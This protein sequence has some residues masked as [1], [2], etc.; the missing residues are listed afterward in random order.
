MFDRH[1]FVA[2][3]APTPRELHCLV[4]HL[5]D[6]RERPVRVEVSDRRIGVSLPACTHAGAHAPASVRLRTVG[7]EHRGTVTE[8]PW[9]AR[10]GDVATIATRLCYRVHRRRPDGGSSKRPAFDGQGRLRGEHAEHTLAHLETVTGL[11]GLL[12]GTAAMGARVPED[13]PEVR[14]HDRIRLDGVIELVVRARVAA[15][16]TFN[17]LAGR[18]IGQR[19]S[20]GFGAVRCLGLAPGGDPV[21][22]AAASSGR[23]T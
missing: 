16:A 8:G 12:D 9:A 11:T 17:A 6:R 21:A 22:D 5:T 18:A 1:L 10:V 19:C 15:P 23:A 14:P 4:A 20:Y 13:A 2:T 7:F 3:G